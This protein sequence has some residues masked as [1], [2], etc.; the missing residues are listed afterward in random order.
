[1]NLYRGFVIKK[2]PECGLYDNAG[3]QKLGVPDSPDTESNP[4][5]AY[6]RTP[7]P[8]VQEEPLPYQMSQVRNEVTLISDECWSNIHTLKKAAY[9][10]NILFCCA[11]ST[12][13]NGK[14][15]QKY[16]NWVNYSEI[17]PWYVYSAKLKKMRKQPMIMHLL[18]HQQIHAKE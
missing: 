16:G 3:S 8:G 7:N 15:H 17:R 10:N 11:I 5:F 6:L 18:Y 14:R 13:R 2:L 9:R 4:Y 12:I 1:M